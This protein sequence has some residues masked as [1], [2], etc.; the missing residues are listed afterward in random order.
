MGVLLLR[1]HMGFVIDNL[2]HYF[3]V[4]VIDA[5][6]SKLVKATANAADFEGASIGPQRRLQQHWCGLAHS[7]ICYCVLPAVLV[8]WRC[9]WAHYG[10]HTRKL[11][12]L[13]RPTQ[14]F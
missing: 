11:Q 12:G 14:S 2:Q 3:Q 9:G 10:A 1:R 5:A 7:R 13:S 8:L 4:D 6:F